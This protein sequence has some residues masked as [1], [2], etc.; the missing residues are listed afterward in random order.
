MTGRFLL[1]DAAPDPLLT[2][3]HR[4]VSVGPSSPSRPTPSENCK[5]VSRQ[6]QIPSHPTPTLQN[7]FEKKPFEAQNPQAMATYVPEVARLTCDTG[8][9]SR[10]RM[11]ERGMTEDEHNRGQGPSPTGNRRIFTSHIRGPC[12]CQVSGI[13]SREASSPWNLTNGSDIHH[14]CPRVLFE[15]CP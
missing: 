13:P 9:N 5:A 10:L 2:K 15:M 8:P 1:G 3:R 12:G 14:D 6:V 7:E 11:T 4:K